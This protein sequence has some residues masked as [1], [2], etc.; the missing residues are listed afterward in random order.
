MKSDKEFIV[1]CQFTAKAKKVVRTSSLEQAKEIVESDR[2]LKIG[3][4]TEIVEPCKVNEVILLKYNDAELD[5]REIIE[6]KS[7]G[8][9]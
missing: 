5:N 4:L 3:E 2:S 9:E 6:Y 1:F 8:A 7:W